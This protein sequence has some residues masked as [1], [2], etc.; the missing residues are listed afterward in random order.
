MTR[1]LLTSIAAACLLAGSTSA[2]ARLKVA[3]T[4]PDL[5][6][7]A[8]AVGGSRA[9]VIS[10]TLP[11]QDPH[12]VDARPHLILKLN[13][14]H[15]LLKVGLQLEVGWLP[16]LV[17]GARNPRIVKGAAGHLDCSSAARLK[18]IPRVKISR[19]MGDIHPGGNP[20]YLVDPHN[21]IA[22]A[23][24]IARRMSKLDGAGTKAY[25]TNAKRFIAALKAARARWKTAMSR[26]RNTPVVTY[27][28]SWIYLTDAMGLRIVAHLEP[29]PGIPPSPAHVLRVIRQ[30]R[31]SRV[32][33]LL[34][35]QYY[36]DR[37]AKLVAK[38]TGAKLLVL[39]GGAL[40]R[41]SETFLQR[42]EKT[43]K[44]LVAALKAK[45]GGR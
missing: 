43:V 6:A 40:T 22:V 15:L 44:Q 18:Q 9:T 41:Q 25:W 20:H 42:M 1:R 27:H 36:P 13:R 19:A 7:L 17:T 39:P 10:L 5:A 24:A 37:T 35:E 29:K 8:K 45:R 38:K 33:L 26:Y 12:F 23:K 28:K 34:Q 4:V 16:T 2:S 32:P 31:A 14:V 30:M 11:T 3:A 21:S